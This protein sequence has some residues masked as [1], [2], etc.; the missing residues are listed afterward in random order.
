MYQMRH[1]GSKAVNR[2][3]YIKM[4][5][6]SQLLHLSRGADQGSPC[7]VQSHQRGPREE[8]TSQELTTHSWAQTQVEGSEHLWNRLL[9]IV[10]WEEATTD[11]GECSWLAELLAE[12][13][14][15]CSHH[16]GLHKPKLEGTGVVL[17][18]EQHIAR[19]PSCDM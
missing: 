10:R 1:E 19:S 7:W 3:K 12:G 4:L 5:T 14:H 16:W 6:L 13:I 11:L 8:E 2:E 9:C 17:K 18:T 15:S